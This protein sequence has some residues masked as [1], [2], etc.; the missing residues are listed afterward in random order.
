MAYDI[1]TAR[2]VIEMEYNGR[3]IDQAQDDL[4]GMEKSGQGTSAGL[5]KM[6]NQA[7]VAGLAVAAGLG[8]AV[9]SAADFEQRLS[10]VKAV[11]GATGAEMDAIRDKAMQ[12]GADTAFSAGESAAAMEEL[13]KA[14]LSVDEVLNGAADATVALAAA[15]GVD[16][17]T[18]A[19]IAS[20]AMN[21]FGLGAKD[22]V[23][24]V[25]Q[26]AGAANA[27]AIDVGDF[28]MS[29]SQVGAVANLAGVNFK[30]TATA[31][32]LMGN[33]GIKGSD[34]GTSLKTMLSNLQPTTKKQIELFKE[35]GII[36]KDGSNQFFDA[37]GNMKS[38]AQ[39][40]GVLDSAVGGMTKQ[41]KMM[42]LETMFG[43]DAIRAAA[44][45]ADEGAGGFRRM[46]AAMSETSAA[47]VAAT[48]M[49]NFKGTLEEFKGSMETAGISIGSV[50]LP[51]L[52]K[53][54]DLLTQ[55]A[56]W[57]NSLSD[58]QQKWIT[59]VVASVAGLLL[60]VAGIVKLVAFIQALKATLA[61]LRVAFAATWASA[62]GPVLLIVAVLAILGAAIML[63]WK[64]NESFRTAVLEVWAAIKSGVSAV[65][66]WFA[67]PFV[68]F[69][70]AAWN[71]IKSGLS[72][73][74]NFFVAA[75]NGIKTAVATVFS[76]IGA[77][78]RAYISVWGAI[79]RGALAVIMGM[80]RAWWGLFGGI[81]KG[82][83]G[84]VIAIVRLGWTIVKGIFIA[85]LRGILIVVRT[86]W[87]AILSVIRAVWNA[88][89]PVVMAGINAVRSAVTSGFNAVR[90]VTSSVWNAIK[91]VISS[92]WGAIRG[93]VSS[94]AS[95]VRNVISDAWSA[96][97]NA[98]S[99]AWNA[100]R[101]AVSDGISNVV[102]L[103]SGLKD[104]VL[105]A[106]SGAATW[107]YNAGADI[108]NGLVNGIESVISRVTDVINSVSDRVA[109]FLPGSPV[110]EGP[111]KV[112]NRGYAGRQ[113]VEMMIGGIADMAAPLAEAMRS[114]VEP[115]VPAGFASPGRPLA[116]PTR[117]R[118]GGGDRSR[119]RM[120][121]GE[122]RLDPSGRAFISGVAS[123][124]VEDD[125]DYDDTLARMGGGE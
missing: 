32:A 64:K 114:T 124:E 35:L 112:L 18:A 54:A 103:V 110:K 30:D 95:S 47:E 53:L 24:V 46:N 26:I 44:V 98:T 65:A 1:G 71:S 39:V 99:D 15:G 7:G 4:K 66:A 101:N 87:N 111:L 105:G 45:I 92:V 93:V 25:D 23:G 20:N 72:A 19:T 116:R 82:L 11:S 48:R 40:A 74:K 34:A 123:E 78:I 84:V 91:S 81:V 125:G 5:Q 63:L 85:A 119:L 57:F 88:I 9:K 43:S 49:D 61:V 108:I 90:S 13:V 52:T 14:G 55:A 68:N 122:L 80:W 22:M 56:N 107:L 120:V 33:A 83:F 41:Q 118:G 121:D 117:R 94:A 27:S 8:L 60:I 3:G 12:L 86:V 51:A 96:V 31:I 50:L 75:W 21:Q 70:V 29:L 77:V 10:A 67:G 58:A 89:R 113:I 102:N 59:I 2:G 76:A 37:Q 73:V 16:M 104:K 38:M 69:F 109:R 79:I 62:L 6:G 17:P 115:A 106:M 28:G 97:R 36:T 42:A 100:V